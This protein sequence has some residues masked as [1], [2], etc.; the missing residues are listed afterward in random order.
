[1]AT[2]GPGP[3]SKP[4]TI[5]KEKADEPR[6]LKEARLRV[7]RVPE[8]RHVPAEGGAGVSRDSGDALSL[9]NQAATV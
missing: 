5:P 2:L 3:K 7:R 4:V 6:E 8:E 9:G 1:M